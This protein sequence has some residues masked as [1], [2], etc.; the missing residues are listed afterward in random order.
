MASFGK[1]NRENGAFLKM[2]QIS[3]LPI[4][5]KSGGDFLHAFLYAKAGL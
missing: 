4:K 3:L 1:Y 2:Q 5:R